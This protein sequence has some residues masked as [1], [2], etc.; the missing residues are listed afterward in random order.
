MRLTELPRVQ[1]ATLPTPIE[2]APRLSAALGGGRILFKRDDL[3][4]LAL[5]GNKVRKL[6][7]LLAEAL[8]QGAD[9]VVTG[10]GPQSNHVRLTAGAARKLGLDP[11]LVMFGDPPPA[12]EGNYLLD[13]LLGAE[14]VFTGSAD[15]SSVDR[16][17]EEVADN[18]RRGGRRPYVIPRGGA[19]ALGSVGY[20]AAALELEEQLVAQRLRVDHL[21]CAVGSCGTVAGL[22][23]GARWLQANYRIWGISVSRPRP[24]CLAGID[25][26]TAATAA[27][28]DLAPGAPRR[29][30]VVLDDYLPPGYGLLNP[31]TAEAIRLVARTEGIFL[32]P[33]YTGKAMAGLID[34]VRRGAIGRDETVLFLH[35]GGAPGLFAHAVELSRGEQ[36]EPVANT[37]EHTAA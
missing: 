6:E 11:V 37:G 26:L 1:L 9:V 8:E 23:L 21:V 18:L 5:G 24:E 4:G 28:L 13:Q 29:E 27:R 33:V 35:T 7:Y 3:T 12:V 22:V 14:I 36:P 19:S 30:L 2:E 17:L 25:D 16:V 15:R 32:D 20:V 31:Q 34:L 10:A